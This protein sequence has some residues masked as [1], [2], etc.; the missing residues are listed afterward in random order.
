MRYSVVLPT[1]GQVMSYAALDGDSAG[2]LGAGAAGVRQ[3]VETSAFE[4]PVPPPSDCGRVAWMTAPPVLMPVTL[5]LMLVRPADTTTE[6]GTV[7]TVVSEE[8][9]V[10]VVSDG[11]AAEIVAV[12]GAEPPTG[13]ETAN[14]VRLTASGTTL[15]VVCDVAPPTPGGSVPVT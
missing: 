5:K 15:T 13:T 11:C 9:S 12:M 4:L 10:I 8:L 7:A 2:A 6:A 14:G 3:I 1:A